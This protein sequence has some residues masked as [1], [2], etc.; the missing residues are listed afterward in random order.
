[1]TVSM[2]SHMPFLNK[3]FD[4]YDFEVTNNNLNN[5]MYKMAMNYTQSAR[6]ASLQLKR[7]YDYIKTYDIN[8][9]P[10]DMQKIYNIRRKVQKY[11][12]E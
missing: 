3:R 10:V 6:N 2:D 12:Y 8:N 5:T 4:K 7:I 1:M 11:L 9:L